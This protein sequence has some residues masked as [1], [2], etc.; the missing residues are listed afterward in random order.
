M[1][2]PLNCTPRLLACPL[3]IGL[4]ISAATAGKYEHTSHKKYPDV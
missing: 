1:L 3:G 2:R 4:A